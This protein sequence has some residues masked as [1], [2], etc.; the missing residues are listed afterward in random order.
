MTSQPGPRLDST[1]RAERDRT[2]LEQVPARTR[3]GQPRT[4]GKAILLQAALLYVGQFYFH[5]HFPNEN[6]A[7]QE[8]DPTAHGQSVLSWGVGTRHD[9]PILTIVTHSLLQS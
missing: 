1:I 5:F 3:P 7:L 2:T 4:S 9:W 8:N 6:S